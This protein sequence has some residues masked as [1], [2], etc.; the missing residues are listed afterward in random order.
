MQRTEAKLNLHYG[1]C[2]PIV[3]IKL[4]TR[5]IAIGCISKIINIVRL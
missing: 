5:M 3:I 1:D 2:D 4:T